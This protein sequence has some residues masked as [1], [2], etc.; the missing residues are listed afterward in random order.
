MFCDSDSTLSNSGVN[1][2]ESVVALT[3]CRHQPPHAT[4]LGGG[5][6]L[7]MGKDMQDVT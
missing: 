2:P 6:V 4:L 1:C 5:M 3:M 7:H